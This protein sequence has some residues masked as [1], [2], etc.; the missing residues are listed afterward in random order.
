MQIC[1]YM[2]QDESD[3]SESIKLKHSTAW[4]VTYI[5]ISA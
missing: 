3:F 2:Y 5:C 1:Q 4:H